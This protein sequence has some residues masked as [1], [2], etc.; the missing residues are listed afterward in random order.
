LGLIKAEKEAA[1]RWLL[2][3]RV[4]RI[5]SELSLKKVARGC[6]GIRGGF[7]VVRDVFGVPQITGTQSLRAKLEAM[8]REC[9]FPEGF[10]WGTAT[11]SYQVEGGIENND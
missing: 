8:A 2:V 5:M 10:M 7:S 11:A 4:R 6:L 3:P 1:M 9:L